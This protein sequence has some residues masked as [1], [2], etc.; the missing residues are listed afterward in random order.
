[1]KVHVLV[2]AG[3]TALTAFAVSV[4]T[5]PSAAVPGRSAVSGVTTKTGFH[6]GDIAPDFTLRSLDGQTVHLSDFR[7]HVV[8]LNFWATWCTPC[9]VEM[10][11]LVAFD[12]QYRAHGMRI[13]GV[14]LDDTGTSRD[15][16]EGFARERDVSYPILLGNTSVADNYGGVRFMPQTFLISPDGKVL[17]STYGITTREEFEANIKGALTNIR[18]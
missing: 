1:M 9:R 13:I 8:V 5:R 6:P 17:S 10:P 2:L 18:R 11:W 12:R 14:N 3:V 15:T 16:I 4:F 7:G